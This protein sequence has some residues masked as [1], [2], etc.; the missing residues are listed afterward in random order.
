MVCYVFAIEPSAVGLLAAATAD[1]QRFSKGFVN[2]AMRNCALTYRRASWR[3]VMFNR[4]GKML[5]VVR[6]C[7]AA[8]QMLADSVP[9]TRA[10]TDA[11][12]T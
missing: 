10:S 1:R 2:G 4:W 8:S 6:T 9:P 5:S 3:N 12:G 11:I 7:I